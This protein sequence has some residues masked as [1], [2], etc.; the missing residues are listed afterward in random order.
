MA[1]ASTAIV[2]GANGYLG[3]H[4]VRALERAGWR[5]R[6]HDLQERPAHGAAAYAPL[7]LLR[8]GD[9]LAADWNADCVF[10]FAGITGTYSGFDQYERFVVLN[11]LGLLNVLHAVRLSG[12]R[13]R[14][15]FPSSRLVYRGADRPLREDDAKENK[16]IYAVNKNAC[17]GLLAAYRNSF[18]IPYTVYRICVPYG[19]EL[20]GDYS[21]G[22]IGNFLRQAR[23]QKAIRLF[24]DGSLRR[25]FTHVEDICRQIALTCLQEGSAGQAYN[26]AGEDFSLREVA[27][28]IAGKYGAELVQEEWPDRDLR[29]ESGH[30]VFDAGKIESAFHPGLLRS[31]GEW[32]E[33][34]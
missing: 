26:V 32:L 22:T 17:E 21:F 12:R 7:D 29:I 13:P 28:R 8:A 14:I 6:G 1:R 27:L 19:N 16:T 11:E 31:F 20:G 4:L 23:E 30:T 25:T 24:G 2:L 5:V 34:L 3:G 10:L 33:R 9:V 18:A 15:V